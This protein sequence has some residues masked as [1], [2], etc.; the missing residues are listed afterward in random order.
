M[1]IEYDF[2]SHAE[3]LLLPQFD[4]SFR[5]KGFLK[6]II[7]PMQE[8][9]TLANDITP[10]FDINVAEGEQLDYLGKLLNVER[11]AYTDD[12]YRNLI[13]SRILINNSTGSAANFISLLKLVL[14][15]IKFSVV[16]QFPATV[17]VLIY[18]PQNVVDEK[19]VNDITPIGVKGI[20]FQNPYEGKTVFEL[21]DVSD[22]GLSQTGGTPMPNV[23]DLETTDVAML[24]VI[25]T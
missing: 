6:S 12:E 8:N 22:D 20:F 3:G 16:E 19:L 17:Q 9:V 25:Y 21:A 1:T 15:D 18:S 5:L 14:G 23:A 11:L 10:S 7:T 13:K 24:N 2:E 4:S